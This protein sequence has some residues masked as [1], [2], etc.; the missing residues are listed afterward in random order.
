M[1][2]RSHLLLLLF[3]LIIGTALRFLRLAALPPWTDEC[4]T[5]VFSLG[6]SFRTVPFNEIISSDTLLQP[7]QANPTVGINAVIER[8]LT[9]STHP[10]VYFVL[11]HFWMK[12]FSPTGELASIWVARSLSAVLGIISIKI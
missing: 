8:L 6:N 7:L 11:A 9:E 4:A 10:P 12:I 5:M 2:H 1:K 3:W